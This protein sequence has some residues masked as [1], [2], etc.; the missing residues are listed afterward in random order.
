M[1]FAPAAGA[2]APP[3]I[4]VS[5]KRSRIEFVNAPL[6]KVCGELRGQHQPVHASERGEGAPPEVARLVQNPAHAAQPRALD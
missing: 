2:V 5:G 6:P 1:V 3:V 4:V